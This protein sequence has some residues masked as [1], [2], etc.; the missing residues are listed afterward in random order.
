MNRAG[1]RRGIAPENVAVPDVS[2]VI[3]PPAGAMTPEERRQYLAKLQEILPDVPSFRD[4]LQKT[5]E[6]P[7]DFDA[8][9]KINGLPEPLRFLDGRPT[10]AAMG[11]VVRGAA[12]FLWPLAVAG[13]W[14]LV[15]L[16]SVGLALLQR[17][18]TNVYVILVLVAS[19]VRASAVI[20]SSSGER[21]VDMV[22]APYALSLAIRK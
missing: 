10:T 8:L 11:G 22:G 18:R 7:P 1:G 6:L 3:E 13:V 4:W 15:A 2:T 9:P 12:P 14:L 19:A 17:E 21:V 20:R 5:G 16:L